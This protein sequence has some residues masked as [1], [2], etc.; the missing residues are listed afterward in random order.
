[1]NKIEKPHSE[2]VHILVKSGQRRQWPNLIYRISMGSMSPRKKHARDRRGCS[3]SSTEKVA[4]ELDW[5]R[6]GSKPHGVWEKGPDRRN[7]RTLQLWKVE[8]GWFSGGVR[9]RRE[10]W[11]AEV[12]ALRTKSTSY[13][14]WSGMCAGA[15]FA[16]E[17][18]KFEVCFRFKVFSRS[19]SSWILSSGKVWTR[20]IN[21]EMVSVKEKF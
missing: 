19:L 4:L 20:D 16:W 10:G 11:M 15:R 17:Q 21:L 13:H 9:E 12:F 5:S 7:R 2:S 3:G 14:C 6:G 1:M 8:P 18:V